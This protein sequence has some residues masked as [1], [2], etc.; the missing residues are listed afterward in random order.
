LRVKLTG[1]VALHYTGKESTL[2]QTL[3]EVIVTCETRLSKAVYTLREC[4]ERAAKKR[5]RDFYTHV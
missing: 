5:L 3:G 4:F 1:S 2:K